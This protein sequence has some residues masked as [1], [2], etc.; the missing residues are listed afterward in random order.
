MSGPLRAAAAC[1]WQIAP[2]NDGDL[3]HC[4]P[5]EKGCATDQKTR[6]RLRR[7]DQRLLE[8]ALQLDYIVTAE[9]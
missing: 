9:N 2:D 6:R 5:G 1:Q 8:I 3:S 7:L 4:G